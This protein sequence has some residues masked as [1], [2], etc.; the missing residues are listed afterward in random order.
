MSQRNI[1]EISEAASH[2]D[3]A[4]WLLSN[5]GIK[6]E[7]KK[8]LGKEYVNSYAEIEEGEEKVFLKECDKCELPQ[9]SHSERLTCLLIHIGIETTGTEIDAT[10]DAL[11]DVFKELTKDPEGKERIS[12]ALLEEI[13][14]LP[15]FGQAKA[16]LEEL[17]TRTCICKKV[18]L[19]ERGLQVHKRKCD[20]SK[21]ALTREPSTASSTNEN[22]MM[23]QLINQM[24]EDRKEE[25]RAQQE[26]TNALNEKN[27][28]I[29]RAQ[30]EQNA[31]LAKAQQ[32]QTRLL[33]KLFEEKDKNAKEM[34]KEVAASHL[35]Q[36][37]IANV[38]FEKCPEWSKNQDQESWIKLV[39]MW[40]QTHHTAPGNQKLMSILAAMKQDHPDEHERL[41]FKTVEC[42]EF[43]EKVNDR[44]NETSQ[45]I[46]EICLKELEVWYGRTKLEKLNDSYESYKKLGQENGERIMDFVRR[47]QNAHLRLEKSKKRRIEK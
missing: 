8:R 10:I 26:Q 46:T 18:C 5:E 41:V 29:A 40:D 1:P 9:I 23:L 14:K 12:L 16:L 15:E 20:V 44:E 30:K 43:M 13:E 47:F 36:Q 3:F 22:N 17:K 45:K 42:E 27:A 28:E 11:Q 24:K 37:K 34:L 39:K 38:R 25:R 35:E 21:N 19:N 33:A 4:G 2:E 6:E 31:E 32:E 7:I